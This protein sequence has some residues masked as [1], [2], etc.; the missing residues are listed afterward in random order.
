MGSG[1]H[2]KVVLHLIQ[3]MDNIVQFITDTDTS[4]Y[5]ESIL[6][7]KVA[8]GDELLKEIPPNTV[9]LAMGLGVGSENTKLILHLRKRF[10]IYKDLSEYGFFF[11]SL[12]HPNSWIARG[13]NIGEGTQVF[14][15]SIIQPDCSIGD[16][17]IIN[18]KVSVD[19]DSVI[20]KSVHL[21]PGVTCGGS[22]EI[23]AYAHISIGATILPNIKIGSGAIVAAGAVVNADVPKDAKVGGIPARII[24]V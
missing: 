18:T 9:D 1:G 16:L 11:P 12:V 4:K 23:G 5:G 2:A 24:A 15:G 10:G 14:A 3:E 20:G 7:V 22:V 17:A 21:A 8:G 13:C 19:H 6:G